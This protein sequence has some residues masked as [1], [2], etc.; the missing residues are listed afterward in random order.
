VSSSTT[1]GVLP[2]VEALAV[3]RALLDQVG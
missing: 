3:V 2:V 1:T